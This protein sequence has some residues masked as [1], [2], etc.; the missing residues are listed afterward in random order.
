MFGIGSLIESTME[1]ELRSARVKEYAFL[2]R[3]LE[4]QGG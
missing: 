4:K 3:W 1:K 2:A